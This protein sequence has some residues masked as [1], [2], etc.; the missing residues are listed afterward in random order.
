MKYI[1]FV[2]PCDENWDQESSNT[3]IAEELSTISKSDDIKFVYGDRHSIF[4]FDS[5]MCQP[6]LTIFVDLIREESEDFMYVLAQVTKSVSSNMNPEHLEHLL[7]I[8]KR[9][10]KPKVE[11]PI[12]K[13]FTKEDFHFDVN[14]FM[15]DHSKKVEEFYNNQVCDLTLDEILDKITD[16]GIESLTRVEK[17]KLDEYSKQI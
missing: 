11:N 1:L 16:Q 15:K 4:H 12:K 5:D 8:N 10:R 3:Q 14:E 9:G 13:L 7:K 17:D 6:E 2:Y